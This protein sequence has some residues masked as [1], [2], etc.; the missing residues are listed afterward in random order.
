MALPTTVDQVVTP[1]LTVDADRLEQNLSTMAARRP[2]AELRPH[3]KAHKCTSLAQQQAAHGHLGFTCATVREVE[4]MAAAGL[5]HDL[6]LANE[7]L[8]ARRLGEV[9]ERTGA[10]VTVAVDSEETIAA[11]V[12]GGVREVL[13]DV[14]VGLPRCGCHPS[15]AGGL[16][17]LARSRGLEVRGVMGYEGHVTVLTDRSERAAA[18]EKAMEKLL[19]AHRDVGG[20]IVSGGATVTWDLNTWVTELQAGSYALMDT[21]FAPMAPE[22]SPALSLESTVISV[23]RRW[24]VCDAGLKSLGMDHGNPTFVQDGYEVLVVSDEHVTFNWGDS[25]APRVGDR[26]QLIPAH[27]DPTVAYHERL[28]IVRGEQVVDTWLVDLRGW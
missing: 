24:A 19:A 26:V 13:V 8:D 10:R 17:D 3:V 2:G 5:G 22:F 14:A 12:E 20:D 21:A 11:A 9:A 27:V 28:H 23:A 15:E 4:G 1:A 16:A 25:E 18:V 7:V 6:L